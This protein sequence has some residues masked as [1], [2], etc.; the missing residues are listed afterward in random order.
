M[1]SLKL[2]PISLTPWFLAGPPRDFVDDK[3]FGGRAW[4]CPLCKSPFLS[5]LDLASHL[6]EEIERAPYPKLLQ[7]PSCKS[8]FDRLSRLMHHAEAQENESC[9]TS[10]I[11]EEIT[12]HIRI[13]V[14]ERD[15][16][17]RP[18]QVLYQLRIDPTR[19]KELIIKVSRNTAIIP[20]GVS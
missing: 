19:Q 4:K 18:L 13:K 11:M 14:A 3:D 10:S 12:E 15:G 5:R 17:V 6:E 9:Q 16:A 20:N 8:G 7:C 1:V 2:L